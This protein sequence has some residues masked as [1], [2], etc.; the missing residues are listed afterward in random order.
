ML[1]TEC[2]TNNPSREA[3]S[4]HLK[5]TTIDGQ[6]MYPPNDQLG[7]QVRSSKSLR[8]IFNVF[9]RCLGCEWYDHHLDRAQG[10]Y[11]YVPSSRFESSQ[12]HLCLCGRCAP[13]RYSFTESTLNMQRPIASTAT[14]SPIYVVFQRGRGLICGNSCTQLYFMYCGNSCTWPASRWKIR[15]GIK[16]R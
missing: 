6:L 12:P 14:S 3:E 11:W 2:H 9:M 10:P 1:H 4:P 7:P 5:V 13:L 15:G 8:A 16:A